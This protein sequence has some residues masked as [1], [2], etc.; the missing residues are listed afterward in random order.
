MKKIK[1]VAKLKD[2]RSGFTKYYRYTIDPQYVDSQYY[3][4]FDGNASC[5]CNR[6]LF[7]YNYDGSKELDCNNGNNIIELVWLKIDG[8]KT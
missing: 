1:A 3:W 8:I 5:D 4:W 7:L 2:T 6:S